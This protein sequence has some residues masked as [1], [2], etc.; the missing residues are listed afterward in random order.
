MSDK[1]I[2]SPDD[3]NK[4]R[5]QVQDMPEE[6]KGQVLEAMDVIQSCG[7][8]LEAASDQIMRKIL[9]DSGAL[10]R[11]GGDFDAAMEEHMAGIQ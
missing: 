6:M 1:I 4:Y 5:D 11:H 10:E 9:S 8:D 3:L 2:V 7:G